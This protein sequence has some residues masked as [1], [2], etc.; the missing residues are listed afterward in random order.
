MSPVKPVSTQSS[1]RIITQLGNG[2]MTEPAEDRLIASRP[3]GVFPVDIKALISLRAPARGKQTAS[4]RCW[5]HRAGVG[6]V[7]CGGRRA[8]VKGSHRGGGVP[9]GVARSRGGAVPVTA[10]FSLLGDPRHIFHSAGST[11]STSCPLPWC[12]AM[13]LS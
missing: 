5:G 9:P 3:A 2:K 8:F 6:S 10:V 4:H 11:R 13:G 1:L 12:F 7:W